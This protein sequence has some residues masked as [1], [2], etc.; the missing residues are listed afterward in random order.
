MQTLQRMPLL[1]IGHGSPMNA[2]EMNED[3]ATWRAL[4]TLLPR[5]RAILCLSAHFTARNSYIV[6]L[7]E[8]ETIH[9]IYGFPQALFDMDYP[10]PGDPELARQMQA[11]LPGSQLTGEW[12]IDH[13]A[14]SVLVHMYPAADV[15]VVQLSLD[16][17]LS[18]LEQLALGARLRPLREEG[19]LILGSGNIVHNLRRMGAADAEPFPWAKDFEAAV[20]ERVMALDGPGIA[21]YAAFHGAA[22]S[23][24]TNEHFVPLL[25][26]MGAAEPG[27]SVTVFNRRPVH[28]SLYMTGY[29]VG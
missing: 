4:G 15:P 23:V 1:F 26:V 5:P 2:I 9:D 25:Y 21:G 24:P 6:G 19:V 3:V 8:P 11:L 18:P 29:R 12:G 17:A 20:H 7:K 14:W 10:A 28:A 13:G 22:A 27:E 16:L